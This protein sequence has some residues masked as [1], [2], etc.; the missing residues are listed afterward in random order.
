MLRVGEDGLH[1][2]RA[3]Y[4]DDASPGLRELRSVQVLRQFW[5]QQY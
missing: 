3:V 5:V 1:I 2:L 4:H